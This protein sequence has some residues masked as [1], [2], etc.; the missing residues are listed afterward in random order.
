MEIIGVAEAT[1]ATPMAPALML[2][3]MRARKQVM[4]V[5][6]QQELGI[7][8][9]FIHGGNLRNSILIDGNEWIIKL[10]NNSC[11]TINYLIT[12][13]QATLKHLDG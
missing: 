1:P 11:I 13:P 5:I 9:D 3:T 12:M 7:M 10:H 4:R 8:A 6:L 2:S